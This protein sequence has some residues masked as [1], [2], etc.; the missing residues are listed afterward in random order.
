MG[1]QSK[2]PDSEGQVWIYRSR[3]NLRGEHERATIEEI[4]K[5]IAKLKGIP[6]GGECQLDSELAHSYIV[7]DETLSTETAARLAIQSEGDFFGGMV[8]YEFAATKAITH[9]LCGCG[10]A[11]PD[12]FSRELG[13]DIK[14]AVLPGFTA[15]SEGDA[16]NAGAILLSGGPVRIKASRDKGGLGQVVVKNKSELSEQLAQCDLSEL[17]NFGLVLE[18]HLHSVETCSVGF[19]SIGA[20][21]VAYSGTQELTR[22]N[23]QNLVYGGSNLFVVRGRPRALLE[24]LVDDRQRLAVQQALTYDLASRRCYGGIIASRRNYDVAQGIDAH[25][26]WKSGV[27]EQSWRVGGASPAEITAFEAFQKDPSLDMVR[28]CCVERYG[29]NIEIPHGGQVYYRGVDHNN[30]PLMKCAW[31]LP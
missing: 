3:Q 13:D 9:P 7:P 6:Y 27:L 4:A 31:V 12:G 26:T 5:R 25:G 29:E 10:A 14:S 2:K 30:G 20:M 8:P 23:H 18:E 1:F 17:A 22:D 19:I 11:C 21:S 16:R 28:V 15:F 24:A